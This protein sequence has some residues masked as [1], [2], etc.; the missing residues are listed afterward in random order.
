MTGRFALCSFLQSHFLA[1][2]TG[3]PSWLIRDLRKTGT[4]IGQLQS[5]DDC[6][7]LTNAAGVVVTTTMNGGPI[8]LKRIRQRLEGQPFAAYL[9]DLGFGTR[10]DAVAIIAGTDPYHYLDI[11]RT[12]SAARGVSPDE[13]VARIRAWEARYGFTLDGAGFDWLLGTFSNSPDDWRQLAAEVREFAPDVVD[14][15]AGDLDALAS[16]LE[17]LNGIYAWWD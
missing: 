8:A 16:E 5:L 6:W 14:R 10:P 13:V 15:G 1:W 3:L 12:N 2:R 7:Q 4:S 9:N 17:Q 11:V